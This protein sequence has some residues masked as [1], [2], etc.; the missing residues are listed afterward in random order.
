MIIGIDLGT[1]NSVASY[2]SSTRPVLIPNALGRF[3]TPSVVGID[4]SGKVIVGNAAKEYQV[5]KP[6]NCASLFKRYMGSD[7]SIQVGGREFTAEQ[8]SS[9]ILKSLKQDAEAFFGTAVNEAVIT[10][11]AYFNDNQRKATIAAGQMA[12][13]DVKRIL[14][15]PTAA[16]MAYGMHELSQDRLLMVLDL[17]G[18]TFD[19]SVVEVFDGS[20][21]VKASS[22]E[23]ILGGEDFTVAMAS[24][25]LAERKQVFEKMEL[26][27][28]LFISRLIHQCEQAKQKLAFGE[29]ATIRIPDENG[30][31]SAQS[32]SVEVD[33]SQF[34]AATQ[35][36]LERI[37]LPIRRALG[38]ADLTRGQIDQV[39]LIG[40]AT[41]MACFQ[42]YVE[43]TFRR[44]P[45]A[46]INPDEAVAF[47]AAVQAGLI[48][49]N[50]AVADL[51]VTDVCPFTLGIEISRQ[52]GNE[53]V[54]QYFLPIIDRNTTI[55]ASRVRR[56]GTVSHGQRS[57]D[58]NIYQGEGRKVTDNLL[59]G[60]FKAKGVP[61]GPAGQEIDVR[62]TYD[63]NGVLEVEAT[64]VATGHR[65]SHVLTRYAKELGPE[66]LK[67]AL[68]QLQSL[69]SH[70]RD[71][72]P[73]QNTLKRAE[74]VYTELPPRLR[75]ELGDFI[76]SFEAALLSQDPKVVEAIR[77]E[78]ESF[79]DNVEGDMR[80]GNGADESW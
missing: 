10:V 6:R 31:Y 18:G 40:G 13:F 23:S 44:T 63:L 12:G 3:L 62:F 55:P 29:R 42:E 20:L 38:D 68:L 56:V 46:E 71:E 43:R 36:I 57:V 70:P 15:E 53:T 27:N 39:L 1:T 64:I 52:L 67:A 7:R 16:A 75:D 32:E 51:V 54:D 14:N 37:E 8:L 50:S 47:G 78:L 2:M 11:P 72:L 45:L 49:N 65:V 26:Q 80:D 74:R 34:N 5:V 77:D 24:H 79:L 66:Q 30:E 60:S 4:D 19:V 69:K 48:A 28:P 76:A 9:L 59:I 35:K 25:L 22:G 17:G 61:D 41:R 73:S 21:E 58:L 33:L